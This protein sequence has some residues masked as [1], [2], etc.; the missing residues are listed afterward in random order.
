MTG[1]KDFASMNL[2]EKKK[3]ETK[4]EIIA[5]T[6]KISHNEN[7]L[8]VNDDLTVRAL[9]SFKGQSWMMA[10]TTNDKILPVTFSSADADFDVNSCGLTSL[11]GCP[12]TVKGLFSCW[13]NYLKTIDGCPEVAQ[14]MNF[15]WLFDIKTI[16][17]IHKKVRECYSISIPHTVT[18]SILGLM[19]IKN[20]FNVKTEAAGHPIP[21]LEKAILIINRHL[22][23]NP[24]VLECQEELLSN[25]LRE[26][27]KL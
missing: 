13:G 14:I 17:G 24:D 23:K 19:L 10:G 8:R 7:S 3:I 1:F 4:I 12:R 21:N 15:N 20:L 5:W 9:G 2:N 27:A 16:S 22:G 26:F 6:K 25:G 11:D 18:S